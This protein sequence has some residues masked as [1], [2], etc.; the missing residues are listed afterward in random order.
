MSGSKK[1]QVGKHKY[2]RETFY[3]D[4]KQYFVTGKTKDEAIRK[5]AL[6]KDK[7]ERGEVGISGNMTVGR[8]I[9]EWLDTYK[10][11]AVAKKQFDDYKGMFAKMVAP[12]IGKLR[13][14]E[15]KDIHL[16]KILNRQAGLSGDRLGKLR[17]RMHALFRQAYASRL[18]LR[19]P[20]E[21]LTLPK[22]TDGTHRSITDFE[23]EHFLKAAETHYAGLM[24]K[25]MLYCGLRTGE[26]VAL[27]WRDI[28]F[29]KKRIHV[30]KAMESGTDVI[31]EPKTKAGIREIPIPDDIIGEL[32]AMKG[33]PFDPVFTRPGGLGRY[34]NMSRHRAWESLKKQMDISM[35]AKF[36]K[37]KA[38]DGKMRMTKVL[39]VVA[40][41]FVPYCLRHTYCTDL[42]DKGV[43]INVAKYLMGHTNISVTAGIYT[44]TSDIAIDQAAALING[45]GHETKE[46]EYAIP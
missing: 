32:L 42:Q 5:A 10:K 46:R 26:A 2:V 14:T 11:P 7:L 34:T 24:F 28:D 36:E 31:K 40:P 39:S 16:Q 20:A 25:V 21:F 22:A 35:G 3:H 45:E 43:P 6:K 15:V 38:K 29:V 27:D 18:I 41:D 33:D 44:H 9:D 19:N 23:R 4:G 1:M 37:R 12:E 17:S 30:T 13:L 8:Y